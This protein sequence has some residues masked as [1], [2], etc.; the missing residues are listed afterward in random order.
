MKQLSLPVEVSPQEVARKTTLGAA[1]ELCAEIGG[2]ALDK[3]LQQEMGADKAQFSRWLSGQEGIIWPKLE[4]LMDICDNDAPL[5]WM[6]CRRGY[7]LGSLRK[8]ESELERELREA[9]ETIRSLE[10][11]RE[12]E[13]Q[14]FREL[15]VSA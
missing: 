13:R 12:V 8:K 3:E 11:D 4:K 6:L 9:K 1:I 15:R 5:L 7:D 14:L 2:Y 10:H